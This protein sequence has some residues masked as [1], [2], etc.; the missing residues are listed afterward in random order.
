MSKSWVMHAECVAVLNNT[1]ATSC[2]AIP[3]DQCIQDLHS[4]LSRLTLHMPQLALEISTP[5]VHSAIGLG[6]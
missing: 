3:S 1:Q 4:L 5:A 6:V 2:M